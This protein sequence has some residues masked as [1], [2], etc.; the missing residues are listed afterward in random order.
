MCLFI[1]TVDLCAEG[2]AKTGLR[3]HRNLIGNEQTEI[4]T[5]SSEGAI[6]SITSHEQNDKCGL[7]HNTE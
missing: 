5:L 3:V 1:T 2:G 7:K 6:F 4:L